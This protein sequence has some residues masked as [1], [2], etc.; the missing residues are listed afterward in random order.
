MCWREGAGP[1][2]ARG[3]ILRRRGER[4]GPVVCADRRLVLDPSLLLLLRGP[5]HRLLDLLLLLAGSG[6]HRHLPRHGDRR[7]LG[8][9]DHHRGHIGHCGH[10]VAGDRP[11]G[12]VAGPLAVVAGGAAA[13][14]GAL[15]AVAASVCAGAHFSVG[16]VNPGKERPLSLATRRAAC[17]PHSALRSDFPDVLMSLL[18]L[19]RICPAARPASPAWGFTSAAPHQPTPERPHEPPPPPPA[20]LISVSPFPS[21]PCC[22]SRAPVEEQLA[23]PQGCVTEERMSCGLPV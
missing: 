11:L 7:T 22:T 16:E 23:L 17:F 2:Q 6:C 19:G 4:R 8:S 14:A 21:F 3:C 20:A 10:F 12:A 13:V 15:G 9:E 5:L 18:G 1:A